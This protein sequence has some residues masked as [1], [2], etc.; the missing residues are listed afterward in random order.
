MN[1]MNAEKSTG[2]LTNFV[3][4]NVSA[5][6]SWALYLLLNFSFKNRCFNNGFCHIIYFKIRCC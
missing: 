6:V 4:Q 3:R 1:G 5:I 2:S